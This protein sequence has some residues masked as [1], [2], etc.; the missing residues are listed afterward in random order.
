M[1]C[2]FSSEWEA[3]YRKINDRNDTIIQLNTK[4]KQT[5]DYGKEIEKRKKKKKKQN[6]EWMNLNGSD[7]LKA[8]KLKLKI[9]PSCTWKID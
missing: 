3:K 9:T 4:K 7:K 6:D 2:F 1:S 5:I 8:S